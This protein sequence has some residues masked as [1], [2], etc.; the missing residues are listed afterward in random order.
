MATIT[1]PL[2]SLSRPSFLDTKEYSS[3]DSRES[4]TRSSAGSKETNSTT[5]NSSSHPRLLTFAEIPEWHQ[6]NDC[7]VAGMFS[8]HSHMQWTIWA[9]HLKSK[10]PSILF[11]LRE[12][13]EY[14]QRT[15]TIPSLPTNI[16]LLSRLRLL[17]NIHA[18]W[19]HQHLHPS[20]SRNS[21]SSRPS[22]Y[23][24]TFQSPISRRYRQRSDHLRCFPDHSN[25]MSRCFSRLPYALQPFETNLGADFKVWFCGDCYSDLGFFYFGRLYGILVWGEDPVDLLGNCKLILLSISFI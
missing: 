1:E 21:L 7:V 9:F 8:S 14:T 3:Q 19:D 25:N 20:H 16:T 17:T 15:D 13:E 5:F 4:S 6:D 10:S 11:E 23:P 12:G 22:N 24:P 18:Q 2:S